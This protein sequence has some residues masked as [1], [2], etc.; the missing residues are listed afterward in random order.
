[1]YSIKSRCVI[2]P[3]NTHCLLVPVCVC[4]F[5]SGNFTCWGSEG[6]NFEID[7]RRG[8][9]ILSKVLVSVNA[10]SEGVD[11]RTTT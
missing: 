7:N 9:G 1:M 3:E 8:G 5:Q 2:G 10:G 6:V 11:Y 4:I